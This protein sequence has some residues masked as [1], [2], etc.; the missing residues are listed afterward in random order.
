VLEGTRYDPA[1]RYAGVAIRY[2]LPG[3]DATRIDLF[4][5]PYGQG[6]DE[7]ALDRAMRERLPAVQ[8]CN[9]GSCGDATVHVDMDAPGK[10]RMEALMRDLVVAKTRGEAS[11]CHPD[12]EDADIA[13][14]S[15]GA[16][17]VAID[18]GPGDWTSGQPPAGR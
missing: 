18:Y 11:T 12:P 14:L 16:E 8:A 4:G 13:A 15:G 6:P 7:D 9:V 17:V 2:F 1:N 5:Y 10:E 3:Q